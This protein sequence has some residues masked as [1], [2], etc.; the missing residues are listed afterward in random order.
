MRAHLGFYSIQF[1]KEEQG[2]RFRAA[3]CPSLEAQVRA[4]KPFIR[5][6]NIHRSWTLM[7]SGTVSL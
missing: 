5:R 3:S 1:W 7:A 4:K 2:S 6:L